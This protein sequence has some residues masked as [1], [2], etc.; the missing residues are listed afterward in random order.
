[1]KITVDKS[2]FTLPQE[3]KRILSTVGRDART[4][5][6]RQAADQ[7]KKDIVS[8]IKTGNSPVKNFRRFQGY[9]P[10][11]RQAINRGRY[12][13]YNKRLRPVN[14]TLSGR[15]LKSIASRLTTEGFMIYF[16]SRLVKY[17]N[18]LGAGRSRV[19]RRILPRDNEVFKRSVM[20]KSIE[21]LTESVE[22]LLAKKLRRL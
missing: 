4:K 13:R 15:M 12:R 2:G 7:L 10:S 22:N 17:H 18:D 16:T 20:I 21:I 11:Y 14:L 3:I 8:T 1:M 19:K 9:S 6:S 5:F